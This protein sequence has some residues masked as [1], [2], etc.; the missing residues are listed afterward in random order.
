MKIIAVNGSP[1]R[2]GN[3]TLIIEQMEKL[4][5]EPI[6]KL[7]AIQLVQAET[8]NDI[9]AKML[10]SDILL[11]VFPLYIDSLPS[12]LIELLT[13]MESAAAHGA[14]TPHVYAVANAAFNAKQTA[15]ALEMIEHFAVRSGFTWGTGVGIGA[16]PMLFQG[17]DNWEK[18]MT[19]GIHRAL[20]DLASTIKGKKSGP[21][22]YIEPHFPH[23]LYK[24]LINYNFRF[25]AKRNGV[26]NLW[27]RPYK[28]D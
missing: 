21:N 1:K 25:E 10:G 17:G 2:A 11:L 9:M 26:R 12:P 7:H 15:L 13:R 20:S 4:L 18:G 24:A 5:D 22:Q 28:N 14:A 23:F 16:G 3:S 19:S 6:E 27:V 8:P